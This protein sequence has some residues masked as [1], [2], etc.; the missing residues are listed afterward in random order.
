MA[1]KFDFMGRVEEIKPLLKPPVSN[2]MLFNNALKVMIVGGPNQRKDFHIEMGEELF[3]QIQGDMDLVIVNPKTELPEAIHIR[4]GEC[5]LLPAGIPHSPQRYANTI[6]LVFER[7]RLPSEMDCLRWYHDETTDP[8][9]DNTK[10]RVLYE[11]YFHCVD[12]GSEI[13]EAIG[14]FH[15]FLAKP[16]SERIALDFS[17]LPIDR[18]FAIMNQAKTIDLIPPFPLKEYLGNLS[19]S[20]DIFNSEFVFKQFR[21]TIGM[22][23]QFEFAAEWKECYFWQFAGNAEVFVAPN[24]SSGGEVENF[25]LKSGESLFLPSEYIGATVTV[26]SSIADDITL[27]VANKFPVE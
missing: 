1:T 18:L 12:L 14:R 23:N 19:N 2:S 4:E 10:A 5:F 7:D 21:T 16:E 11:E 6:G 20:Q 22:T 26:S 8:N 3:Y 24:S 9:H 17:H 25:Q 27:L 13:K 15:A